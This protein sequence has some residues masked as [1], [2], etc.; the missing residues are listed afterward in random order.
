ELVPGATYQQAR[1]RLEMRSHAALRPKMLSSTRCRARH[2]GMDRKFPPLLA[3][4]CATPVKIRRS[5]AQSLTPDEPFVREQ[6]LCRR[7]ALC[8]VG[9]LVNA[10]TVAR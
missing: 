2:A 6:G 4:V 8:S 10:A 5:S 7:K 9:A 3:A 1:S